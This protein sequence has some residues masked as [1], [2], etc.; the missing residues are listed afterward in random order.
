MKKKF[1]Q[2]KTLYVNVL[3]LVAVLFGQDFLSPDLQL[4]IL[5]GINIILRFVTKDKLQW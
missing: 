4:K 5:A 2:S 3:S 1:W